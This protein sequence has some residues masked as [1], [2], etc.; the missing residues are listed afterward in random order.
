M[1]KIAA[2]GFEPPTSG[3]WAPRA[4][5]CATLLVSKVEFWILNNGTKFKAL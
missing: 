1:K 5:H 2:K 3:L 4:N